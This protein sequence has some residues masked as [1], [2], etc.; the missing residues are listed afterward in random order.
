MKLFEIYEKVLIVTDNPYS[1]IIKKLKSLKNITIQSTSLEHD[2]NTLASATNL[3]TSG[4][5]TFLLL[6][7]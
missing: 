1:K 6:L 2:F 4:V 3:A 5:G 7:Q